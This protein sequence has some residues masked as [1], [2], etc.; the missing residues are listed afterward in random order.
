MSFKVADEY[1]LIGKDLFKKEAR[2]DK[3]I[4]LKV[5]LSTGEKGYIEAPFGQSGKFKVR[6][7]GGLS[8]Q[9]M[10]LFDNKGKGKGKGKAPGA[11]QQSQGE[12]EEAAEGGP[13]R[14]QIVLTFKKYIFDE[15]KKIVQ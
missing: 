15:S 5:E 14:P 11:E 3:F 7:P 12:P 8:P 2:M 1:S 6:I 13:K 9:V 10:L 4:G